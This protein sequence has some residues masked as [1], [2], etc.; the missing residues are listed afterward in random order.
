MKYLLVGLLLL[1][2]CGRASQISNTVMTCTGDF[3]LADLSTVLATYTLSTARDGSNSCTINT[4]PS[5]A[6]TCN[7]NNGLA[8]SLGVDT[9]LFTNK[10][11]NVDYVY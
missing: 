10:V 7:P 9:L 2:G 3:T 1:A 5:R 11:C 4:V 8:A 6:F